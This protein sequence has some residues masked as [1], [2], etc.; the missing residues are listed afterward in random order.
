RHTR[1][2]RDWSSDVC[3]S[4]LR[5]ASVDHHKSN[6]FA[7]YSFFFL[8]FKSGS[9]DEVLSKL[10]N[11]TESCFQWR[12]CVIDVVAVKAEAFFK[13]QRI[14]C[15]KSNGFD[16]LVFSGLKHI[17]PY[18]FGVLAGHVEFEAASSR[19]PGVRDNHVVDIRERACHK[20]IVRYR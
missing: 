5:Y 18:S 4:D 3:S 2:S 14:A 13:P 15:T 9:V 20:V 12:G 7:F 11:P 16:S 6:E 10:R 8:T 19:I 1:F 17:V